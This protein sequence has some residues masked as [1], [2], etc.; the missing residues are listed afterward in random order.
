MT[1]KNTITEWISSIRALNIDVT[2]MQFEGSRKRGRIVFSNYAWSSGDQVDV[3]VQD[4][5]SQGK[6]SIVRSWHVRP[7][8]V[9][10]DDKW[11]KWS[12]LK[13]LHSSEAKSKPLQSTRKLP[14]PTIVRTLAQKDKSKP[15]LSDKNVKDSYVSADENMPDCQLSLIFPETWLT[16]K[17]CCSS[18]SVLV[19]ISLFAVAAASKGVLD[20]DKVISPKC[21]LLFPCWSVIVQ[22]GYEVL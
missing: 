20:L 1:S 4:S 18:S 15:L 6:T 3:W 22:G 14:I 19:I 5:N 10:K 11:I 17:G 13:G 8:L 9:W 12:S 7:T 2:T 16:S 21:G